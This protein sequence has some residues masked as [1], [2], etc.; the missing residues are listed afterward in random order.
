MAISTF[1]KGGRK[2]HFFLETGETGLKLVI[3]LLLPVFPKCWD[4]GFMQDDAQHSEKVIFQ[5]FFIS[6]KL[7]LTEGEGHRSFQL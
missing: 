5:I 7:C 1:F 3:L 6:G 2:E 4:Y